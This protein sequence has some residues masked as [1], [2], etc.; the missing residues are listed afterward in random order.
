MSW[1]RPR[2]RAEA[3]A[4]VAAA[5]DEV[6]IA[7]AEL[8][9]AASRLADERVPERT[10]L[11]RAGVVTTAPSNLDG[12]AAELIEALEGFGQRVAETPLEAGL[13]GTGLLAMRK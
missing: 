11:R 5:Q 1:W 7:S 9:A 3:R 8:A 6:R 12:A 2:S 13:L 4:A 10:L